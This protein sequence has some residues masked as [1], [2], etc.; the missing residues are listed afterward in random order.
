MSVYT[1]DN[2]QNWQNL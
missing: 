1:V 2:G